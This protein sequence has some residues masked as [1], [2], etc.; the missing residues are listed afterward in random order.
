MTQDITEVVLHVE[1]I[2]C[3]L[4][5]PSSIGAESCGTMLVQPESAERGLIP[6]VCCA[7]PSALTHSMLA[8]AAAQSHDAECQCLVDKEQNKLAKISA[9]A[10]NSDLVTFKLL[11]DMRRDKSYK[12]I[13]L[14]NMV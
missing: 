5:D 4:K 3:P 7:C 9:R 2:R 1:E 8:L 11:C 14:C 13:N 6:S 10:N 12:P